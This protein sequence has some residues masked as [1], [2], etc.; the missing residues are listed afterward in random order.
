[1][2]FEN[3][4]VILLFGNNIVILLFENNIVILLFENNIVIFKI[5]KTYT[6]KLCQTWTLNRFTINVATLR[7]GGSATSVIVTR[8]QGL[9]DATYVDWQ[10]RAM[11]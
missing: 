11:R 6:G 9:L 5:K 2:L 4:I 8:A 3:N 1:M 7:T 10:N